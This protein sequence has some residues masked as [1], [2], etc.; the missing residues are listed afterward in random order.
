MLSSVAGLPP[1]KSISHDSHIPNLAINLILYNSEVDA[2]TADK[3]LSNAGYM[4]QL[5]QA[6]STKNN[7]LSRLVRVSERQIAAA[8]G[9]EAARSAS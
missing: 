1:N 6:R 5:R 7:P 8:G 9:P 4:T 3:L 2:E